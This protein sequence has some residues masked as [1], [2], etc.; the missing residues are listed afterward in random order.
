MK[1]FYYR[2]LPEPQEL[3]RSRKSAVAAY[4]VSL[5]P[6]FALSKLLAAGF[7]VLGRK[8]V[9]F[10]WSMDGRL[11]TELIFADYYID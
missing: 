11:K 1:H 7:E 8:F 3:H 10:E 2:N 6:V 4:T 5:A 9:V